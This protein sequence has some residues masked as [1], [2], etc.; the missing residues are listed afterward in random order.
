MEKQ[1]NSAIKGRIHSLESF[2]SVDGPGIR[3]VIFLQGCRMR[4]RFCHNPDTW[5]INSDEAMEMTA[6]EILEKALR[7]RPY[8]KKEGG[9]TVSGGEPLIQIDFLIE[10]FRKAK[11][12]DVSTCIDTAG[13]PFTREEPY[14]S[15]FKELAEL[16]DLFIVDI[17][18]INPEDHMMLTGV[19]PD[20]IIDM[21]RYLDEIGKAVW[22][23]HVL[24][25]GDGYS[26]NDDKLRRLREFID[27]LKSVKKV[28]I[29]PYHTLGQH[30]WEALGMSYPLAGVNPPTKDRVENAERILG[31]I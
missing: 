19:K 3:Y 11:E 23:R 15:R 4:C 17:K 6:D 22:I 26:D 10:L 2:G 12:Q 13:E 9:I 27:S 20:N 18:D 8:W 7:F 14:F 25:P 28:E 31:I 29:L 30:K 21:L 5:E 1:L 24:V 16:T